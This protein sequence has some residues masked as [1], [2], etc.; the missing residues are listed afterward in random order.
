MYVQCT[1][2]R[3]NVCMY[4]CMY[5]GLCVGSFTCTAYGK[6][7]IF[8]FV[9]IYIYIYTCMYMYVQVRKHVDVEGGRQ[10]EAKQTVH[11]QRATERERGKTRRLRLY[12]GILWIHKAFGA[13]LA[14]VTGLASEFLFAA[15]LFEFCPQFSKRGA[16]LPLGRKTQCV[17]NLLS[18]SSS[19]LQVPSLVVSSY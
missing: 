13:V 14:R 18:L 17:P 1:I 19:W 6:A 10:R 12:K 4:V 2:V 9:Y 8:L 11:I 15:L 16:Q 5:A 3:R 7:Y